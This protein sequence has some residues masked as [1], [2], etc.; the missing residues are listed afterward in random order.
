MVT[1][2]P[3]LLVI[4]ARGWENEQVVDMLERSRRLQGLVEEHNAL[5]DFEVG[6]LM[7]HA[8]ALLLPS[9]AEGF[10]LPI[11]EALASGVPVICSDISAFREVGRDAPEYLDPFDLPA[12]SDVVLE[13]CRPDS[14][15]RAAQ[16]QRLALWRAPCWSD[17]FAAV[18]QLLWE[19]RVSSRNALSILP[20]RSPSLSNQPNVAADENG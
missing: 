5:N 18:E 14:S 20:Q 3:R 15:M 17:H 12:W 1:A 8:R 2:P 19:L 11:A 16:M 9:F 4:G 6:A 13:Y 10:G 7:H